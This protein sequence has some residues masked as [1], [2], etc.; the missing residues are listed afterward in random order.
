MISEREQAVIGSVR[1]YDKEKLAAWMIDNRFATG[2]GDTMD[3]LLRELT[4]Q[5][6]EMKDQLWSYRKT[7]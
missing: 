6:Q 7:K 1:R 3:D 2:H 4:W 5:V